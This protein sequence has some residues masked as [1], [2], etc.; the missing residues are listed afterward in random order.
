M[1]QLQAVALNE[2]LTL[3]E[4]GCGGKRDGSNWRHFELA[5]WAEP[6]ATRFGWSCWTD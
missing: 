3:Q 5:W 4:K 6:L 2:G 1:N